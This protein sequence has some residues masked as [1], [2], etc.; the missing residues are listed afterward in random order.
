M[1]LFKLRASKRGDTFTIFLFVVKLKKLYLYPLVSGEGSVLIDSIR[2]QFRGLPTGLL[3]TYFIVFFFFVVS[4]CHYFWN[5]DRKE[6][7][8]DKNVCCIQ[9]SSFFCLCS[10]NVMYYFFFITFFGSYL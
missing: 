3:L 5:I 7:V 8:V 1:F 2:L 10:F 9:V 4:L 6:R